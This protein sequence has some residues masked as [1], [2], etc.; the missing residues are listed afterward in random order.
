MR[1]CNV[2]YANLDKELERPYGTWLRT[3]NKNVKTGAGS[4]WLRN[5]EGRSN[6]EETVGKSKTPVDGEGMEQ[7]TARFT[8]D[9]KSVAENQEDNAR[10]TVTARN[11][12]SGDIGGNFFFGID[13]H[14]GIHGNETYVIDPK[15]RRT[16]DDVLVD[17]NGPINMQTDGIFQIN[18][19]EDPNV[20]KNLNGAGSVDQARREL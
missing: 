13:V 14:G 4:R 8:G 9:G 10:I 16:A 18:K 12:D 5:G 19:P 1:D 11:Q 3:P 17:E 20:S 6:W 7:T 15:R 2:V